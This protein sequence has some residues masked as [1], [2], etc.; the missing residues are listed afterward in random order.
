MKLSTTQKKTIAIVAG[1]AIVIAI[2]AAVTYTPKKTEAPVAP[3]PAA[4]ETKPAAVTAP[5]APSIQGDTY[6]TVTIATTNASKELTDLVGKDNLQMVL[7]VNR[8]DAANIKK[9]AV[10]IIP[11]DFSDTAALSPFPATLS[12]ASDIPKLMMVDQAVQ[13]FAIY[14]SGALVRWGAVSSGK[15]S[16]PTANKLYFTN[17][18]G[19]EVHSSFSDEWI[20]KWNFNLDNKEGIGMHQYEMPGYPASHS[21]VR[22]FGS[23]AEWIYNW[24]DQWVLSDDEQTVVQYG[25]PV[26]VFGQY[27]FGKT[28]PWK[29]LAKNADATTVSAATLEKTV[30][31]YHD[32]ILQKKAQ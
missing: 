20:L 1:L 7:E 12:V 13:A 8:I 2:A 24:A 22:M 30:S 27:P 28:A 4:T 19:K 21:C 15:Q 25:T 9:G 5:V 11:N 6:H 23:D 3:V 26:I 31:G 14:E 17:W 18:K 16:T 29:N 32:E 10:V